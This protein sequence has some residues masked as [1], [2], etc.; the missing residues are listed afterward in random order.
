MPDGDTVAQLAAVVLLLVLAVPALSTAHEFAGTPMA[1]E[2]STT[3]DYTNDYA[4]AQNATVE[5]YGDEPV[6]VVD[7]AELVRGEDYRW[8][9]TGG[10][11]EWIN[12]TN[13]TTGDSAE[14]EY[15]AYQ[16]TGETALAWTIIT[17]FMGLFGVFALAASVRTLWSY[18]AEVWDL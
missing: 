18:I 9:A 16:R 2:E 1:Y 4:V 14:I 6:I 15:Q 10:T 11:V 12:S 3:V 17:P 13:T 7:G 8:N 5:G